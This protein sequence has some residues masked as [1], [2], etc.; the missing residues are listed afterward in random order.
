MMK[1][2]FGWLCHNHR[3]LIVIWIYQL[4]IR[5]AIEPPP[6][7]KK[8]N[9]HEIVLQLNSWHYWISIEVLYFSPFI[10]FS[11]AFKRCVSLYCMHKTWTESHRFWHKNVPMLTL[12]AQFVLTVISLPLYILHIHIL[13]LLYST[14]K[15]LSKSRTICESKSQTM[16][17]LFVGTNKKGRKLEAIKF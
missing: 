1:F 3:L 4:D 17:K 9:D 13:F 16:V 6:T 11:F 8:G 7:W 12:C 5:C 15:R 14:V 2:D 10:M